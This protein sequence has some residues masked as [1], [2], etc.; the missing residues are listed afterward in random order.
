MLFAGLGPASALAA[1]T[2]M[3]DLGRASTYA[4]LSGASVGNTVSAPGAPHT[5]LR[6]DLGVKANSQPT[7]FP[8]GVVTGT[9]RVGSSADQ[10]HAALVAAYIEVAARPNGAPLAA[11]LAGKTVSPGL[12]SIPAAAS[13]T[14]TL[15]LD[16]GGNPNAVFVFQVDGALAFAAGSH[17]VLTNGARASRVF[18]QVNGAGTIGANADFAGTLMTLGAVGIGNGS[19]VNGRALARTGAVAF[20]ANQ[21]YG[22]APKLTIDGGSS[23]STTGTTPTISGTTDLE[24]PGVVT[25]TL[26]GRTFATSPSGGRWSVSSA[27][28]ANGNYPVVASVT[29]AVGNR[30]RVTQRLTVDTVLPIVRIDGGPSATT[31][32]RTPTISG[33]SDAAVGTVVRVTVG[34]QTLRALVNPKDTWNIR[35]TALADGTHYVT[36]SVRDPAGNEGIDSQVLTVDTSG[37]DEIG[38]PETT[39]TKDPPTRTNALRVKYEFVSDSA[40][41]SFECKLDK[42]QFKPCASPRKFK[43]KAGRHKFSVRAID[44]AGN[45]DPTADEDKFRVVGKKAG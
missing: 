31:D 22:A 39:I 28:L 12:H 14:G 32:D 27:I 19:L 17:V 33:T 3:V 23:A 36:A 24:A 41:S 21:V 6:G 13:N 26:A 1:P 20:D 34:S 37:P 9:T 45:V 5:T 18:W 15:T 38:M 2:N 30:E 25:V 44:A 42:G 8:P 16:A 40:R 29:D 7:G 35:P 4:A 10:A 11:A 43:V